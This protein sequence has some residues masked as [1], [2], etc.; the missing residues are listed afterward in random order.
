MSLLLTGC[1][2]SSGHSGGNTTP[3]TSV[4]T[5]LALQSMESEPASLN[6]VMDVQNDLTRLFGNPDGTPVDIQTGDTVK[7][8]V[9]YPR[10]INLTI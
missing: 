7:S 4:V 2:S 5:N 9:K 8:I 3:Q 1:F 6:A 10:K